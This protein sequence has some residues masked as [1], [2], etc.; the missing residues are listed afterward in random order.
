MV[1]VVFDD[2]AARTAL[3]HAMQ[4]E[5]TERAAFIGGAAVSVQ[6]LV[7]ALPAG[8]PSGRPRPSG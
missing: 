4:D 3:P 8:A 6:G 7:P 1:R 2:D 5:F